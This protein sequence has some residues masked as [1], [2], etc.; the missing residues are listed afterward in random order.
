MFSTER[1]APQT[2]S[3]PVAA[4]TPVTVNLFMANNCSCTQNPGNRVFNVAIDGNPV[5][6]NYDIV[7]DVGNLVGEMKSF[8]ATAPANGM[9]TVALTNGPSD[10]AVINGVEVTRPA[11]LRFRRRSMST[12]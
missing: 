9:V 6:S 1:W 12:G 11:R 3:F 5:L 8:N 7:A 10:N 4:G 2:Y